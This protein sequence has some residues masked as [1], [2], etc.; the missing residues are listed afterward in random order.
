MILL[1]E[2]EYDS[3]YFS[4][5]ECNLF[6]STDTS[7]AISVCCYI[8]AEHFRVQ[9]LPQEALSLIEAKLTADSANVLLR[10][11]DSI[12]SHP[13]RAICMRHSSVHSKAM[14]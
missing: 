13:L 12:Q 11:A 8:L 7:L 4:E 1:S 3:L 10:Y 2:A 14:T 5:T 9:L 6:F